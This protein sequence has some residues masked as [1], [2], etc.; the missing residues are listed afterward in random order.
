MRMIDIA[1]AAGVSA[2]T[3][4]RVIRGRK[5]ISPK[6]AALVRRVMQEMGYRPGPAKSKRDGREQEEIIFLE[7]QV[8]VLSFEATAGP[9]SACCL[10]NLNQLSIALAR[11]GL[12]MTYLHWPWNRELPTELIEYADGFI[13]LEGSVPARVSRQLVASHRTGGNDGKR[14]SSAAASDKKS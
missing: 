3:V 7:N 8:A 9:G 1:A 6:T 12:Q 10:N 4:S 2:S 5:N 14:R 13:L 11:E